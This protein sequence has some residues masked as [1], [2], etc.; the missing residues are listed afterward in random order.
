MAWDFQATKDSAESLKQTT[1]SEWSNSAFGVD[2][3]SASKELTQD[4]AQAASFDNFDVSGELKTGTAIALSLGWEAGENLKDAF[5]DGDQYAKVADAAASAALSYAESKVKRLKELW[6]KQ[7][8]I[9]VGALVGEI[10]PCATSFPQVAKQVLKKSNNLIGYLT[11]IDGGDN[12]GDLAKNFGSQVITDIIADPS[13]T[14]AVS[15]LSIL[16]AYGNVLNSVAS[17]IDTGK[18]IMEV[19]EPVM[20]YL[21]IVTNFAMAWIN[22]PA[23]LEGTQK[24]MEEAGRAVQKLF[25]L[26]IEPLRKFVYNIKIQMPELLVGAW[27]SLS[28]QEAAE[29]PDDNTSTWVKEWFTGEYYSNTVNSL[30]WQNSVNQALNSMTNTVTGWSQFDFIKMD[31]THGKLLKSKFLSKV[32]QNYMYG[33]DGAIA[34]AKAAAHVRTWQETRG[35]AGWLSEWLGSSEDESTDSDSPKILINGVETSLEELLRGCNGIAD[36]LSILQ[37]SR[38]IYNNL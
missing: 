19:V 9:T 24:V 27:S 1:S 12:W 23:T 35:N 15:Q 28:I 38:E 33:A 25:A 22:A 13:V 26:A 34:R 7:A 10:A 3:T 21:E 17:V 5:T 30:Q 11:G 29:W 31:S 32:V 8:T 37:T 16:Q 18:Q 36:E 20:P 14:S 4:W 2:T 6:E